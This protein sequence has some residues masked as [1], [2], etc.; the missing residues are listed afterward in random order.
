[1]FTGRDESKGLQ[2]EAGYTPESYHV[3]SG[4]VLEDFG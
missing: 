4:F 2:P 3:A 1:L